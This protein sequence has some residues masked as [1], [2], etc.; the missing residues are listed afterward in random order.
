MDIAS[1][2][3]AGYAHP[4]TREWQS[5]IPKS[6]KSAFMFPVFVTDTSPDAMEPIASMPEQ[7]RF[8]VDKLAENL[9]PLM[10][11]GLAS[12]ILFGVPS[13]NSKLT[14]DGRGSAADS[15][16]SCVIQAIKMCRQKFPNLLI[17]CDVCLCP[18]TDH[19]H[20]GILYDDGTINNAQSG[21]RLA[22]ISVAY[23]QA[24]AH[25]V[26]P[27]DM[28]DGRIKALKM[29]LIENHLAHRVSVMAYSAKFASAFYGPFRD[30]AKSAPSK[31][32]RKCYQLPPGGRGLARRAIKRDMNEGADFIM[33]KP[34]YPY[35][36]V[37][38]DASEISPDI[39]IAVYQVSG[40]YSMLYHAGVT[41]GVVDIKD[42]VLESIEGYHRAGANIIL[43]YWT[44][45]LLEWLS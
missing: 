38:R 21:K 44:P 19:G 13:E 30:A 25:I 45:K 16:D 3:H 12:I 9:E 41:H 5:R 42:A 15:A 18:Y 32:D 14:K 2:L 22:E 39:P 29:A 35:L 43:T 27:S 33:V 40:E 6:P 8:G 26:A 34:G 1:L 20:C 36:D 4:L 11:K 24:G 17:A 37:V 31:G 10:A 28:C 23:A 7:F